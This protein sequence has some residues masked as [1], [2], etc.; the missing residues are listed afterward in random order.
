[1]HISFTNARFFLYR[2]WFEKTS[3]KK[4]LWLAKFF[5]GSAFVVTA[6]LLTGCEVDSQLDNTLNP[7]A[8][9]LECSVSDTGLAARSLDATRDETWV[10]FS[11]EKNAEVFPADPDNSIGWDI[12]FQRFRMKVNGGVSG[13]AG[14]EVA[15]LE[16]PDS[17]FES[18]ID[19]SSVIEVPIVGYFTDRPL[20]ELSDEDLVILGPNPFFD[21]C[22]PGIECIDEDAGTV[23]R[24]H[25]N[26]DPNIAAF[27]FLTKGSG[28]Y[29]DTPEDSLLGWYDYYLSEGSILRSAGDVWMI[30]SA[31]GPVFKFQ[32]LNYNGM[33]SDRLPGWMAFQWQSMEAGI[34]VA[35]CVEQ[36]QLP[37]VEISA[38]PIEGGRPLT[39][40]FDTAG[41]HDPDGEIT[42]W[43]WNFG[44]GGSS[45]EPNPI[46]LY[47]DIGVY[48]VKLTV[49]DNGNVEQE[50]PPASVITTLTITVNNQLP[51]ANAGLDQVID[52]ALAGDTVDVTLDAMASTD[53]D[54]TI[55]A[56]QWIGTPNADDITQP[57]LT[58]LT[59]GSYTYTLTVTDNDGGSDEDSVII[60]I[61]APGNMSPSGAAN[62][63]PQNGTAPLDVQF[64]GTG[65]DSDGSIVSYDWDF[66]NGDTSTEQSPA[67]V[68]TTPGTYTAVLVVTDNLGATASDSLLIEVYDRQIH[69]PTGDR[70]VYEFTATGQSNFADLK[71]WQHESNHGGRALMKFDDAMLVGLHQDNIVSATLRFYAAGKEGGFIAAAP[72]SADTSGNPHAA[73]PL[74]NG[75]ACVK[76]DIMTQGIPGE[77]NTAWQWNEY[78]IDVDH[79]GD[80]ITSGFD[81][82]DNSPADEVD[83]GD[84][85]LPWS[86]I[87][88][89]DRNG[90]VLGNNEAGLAWASTIVHKQY[91]LAS[92][93][94]PN[95][96]TDDYWFEWD[97]KDLV[98]HWIQNGGSAGNG[99][100]IT[101]E[102]DSRANLRADNGSI[103]VAAFC[104][105]ESMGE[106]H[107]IPPPPPAESTKRC[108]NIELRPHLIIEVRVP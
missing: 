43:Q 89:V 82:V 52:L 70:G 10:Y 27:V 76:V 51:V 106:P 66:G 14:V 16:N 59:A 73:N 11:L 21:A 32:M 18:F 100:V 31:L 13:S 25:L 96:V 19:F 20:H 65:S 26:T 58:A 54:G 98:I 2:C 104:D 36:N 86:Q 103:P 15:T 1:M 29:G 78:G 38:T 105:M 68:Y 12:A 56:Y 7:K 102:S 17:A 23:D 79:D 53:I 45:T 60:T 40:V 93:I 37:L 108:L 85:N 5:P 34:T 8:V 61:N 57:L 91:D 30:R 88:E 46:H 74:C 9:S 50:V 22:A 67:Y 55:E 63:T 6:F 48:L 107:P 75:T 33:N 64:A 97:L 92:A 94:P 77:V 62:A 35:S 101:Q 28:A 69:Y 87:V 72:G 84:C 4:S 90:T 71:V 83:G 49:T 41:S 42:S 24:N 81:S 80:C 95:P 47:T 99:I 44:D 3:R 39:V